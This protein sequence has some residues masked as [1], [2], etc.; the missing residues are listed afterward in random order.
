[1]Y[2]TIFREIADKENGKFY[3][4]DK[5]ISGGLGVRSPN[6][7]FKLVFDYKGN[8]FTI[9][10]QVGT[11]YV[12]TISCRL[13]KT[14]QPIV[15]KIN[16]ISHFK[17]LFLRKKSKFTIE[18]DNDNLDFFLNKNASL[19]LLSKIADKDNFTPVI[20]CEK[21]DYWSVESTYHLEFDNWTDVINPTIQLFKD[22]IKEFDIAPIVI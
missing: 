10:N 15:F 3:Y 5:D 2:K 12:G 19:K 6:V 21:N 17:N 13:S 16:T 20:T 14:I 7:T 11:A 8:H 4:Q 9:V 22:L 18:T 1:M